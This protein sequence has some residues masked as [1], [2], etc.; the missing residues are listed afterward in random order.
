[1]GAV[2]EI[3]GRLVSGAGGSFV[4]GGDVV[5]WI[6]LGSADGKM[7][8]VYF[9]FRLVKFTFLCFWYIFKDFYGGYSILRSVCR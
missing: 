1:M 8:Y 7:E 6:I 2:R 3:D 9:F 4:F 5:A